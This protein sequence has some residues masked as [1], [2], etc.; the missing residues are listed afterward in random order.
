ML[1]AYHPI[2]TSERTCQID[3]FVPGPDIPDRLIRRH[4]VSVAN[5]THPSRQ[6]DLQTRP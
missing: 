1:S 5:V 6:S 2:K 4:A 3:R